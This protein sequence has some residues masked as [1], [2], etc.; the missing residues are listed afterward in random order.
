MQSSESEGNDPADPGLRAFG[1]TTET[2]ELLLRPMGETASEAMGSMGNDTPIACLSDLPRPMFDFF[3]QRFTGFE[4]T[5]RPNSRIHGHV[6][7]CL[8]RA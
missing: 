5:H 2:L 4:P 6:F 8:D 1:Y 7:E 3:Y